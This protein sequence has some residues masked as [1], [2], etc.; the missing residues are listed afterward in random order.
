M[1]AF[2]EM[3]GLAGEWAPVR[4]RIGG[5]WESLGGFQGTP[6]TEMVLWG[7]P[8]MVLGGPWGGSGDPWVSPGRVRILQFHWF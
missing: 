3:F 6:K 1:Q 5:P 8:G 7:R 4:T 2:D